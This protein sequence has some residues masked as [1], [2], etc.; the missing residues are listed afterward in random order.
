MVISNSR[1]IILNLIKQVSPVRNTVFYIFALFER[2]CSHE[3][4]PPEIDRIMLDKLCSLYLN[5]S[6]NKVNFLKLSGWKPSGAY[7]I[8]IRTKKGIKWS[9]VYKNAK[10]EQNE[11]PAIEGLPFIPGYPEF[12]VYNDS[13][14]IIAKYLPFVFDCREIRPFKQYQ[15]VLEDLSL[16]N[17][18]LS[19][20]S[21][22]VILK[23][24]S[25]LHKFHASLEEWT[26]SIDLYR[27]PKYDNNFTLSLQTY[28][29]HALRKY[30]S[31]VNDDSVT[32]V[33]NL[34]PNICDVHKSTDVYDIKRLHPIHGD[35]N[36]SNVWVHRKNHERLKI[37]DWEWIGF[38]FPHADLASLLVNSSPKIEEKAIDVFYNEYNE[39]S[40]NQH[41]RIYQKCKLERAILNGSFIALQY[42]NSSYQTKMNMAKFVH[43]AMKHILNT[44]NELINYL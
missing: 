18:R 19:E 35:L 28:A 39:L 7:R 2:A 6:I 11:I 23:T 1:E 16:N 37:V 32:R 43:N 13:K 5:D 44:Y 27:I 36:P 12:L 25:K 8:F 9:L 26:T 31:I 17:V 10:Y 34:W 41:K 24:V 29:Y 14:G 15:Y 33:L 21:H 40:I 22:D 30:N 20:C 3:G 38:G 42:I 4:L